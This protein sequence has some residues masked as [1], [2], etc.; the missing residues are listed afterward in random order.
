M[1]ANV[2]KLLK[3]N[4]SKESGIYIPIDLETYVDKLFQFSKI[5]AVHENGSFQGFISYYMNDSEKRFGYLSMI[6]INKEYQN[7][8]MGSFLIK[9][10]IEDLKKNLF[11]VFQ[12]EV[13]K[14]NDKAIKIYKNFGF[15]IIKEK[16]DLYLMEL[17]FN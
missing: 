9:S 16:R 2:L 13:L 5:I 14:S 4:N 12:L 11:K 8:G 7:N 6:L 1:K 3:D 10:A 15:N 17:Q